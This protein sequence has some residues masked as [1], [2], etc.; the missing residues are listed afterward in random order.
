MGD[1]AQEFN[2]G[3]KQL[4]I[5]LINGNPKFNSYLTALAICRN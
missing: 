3:K 2:V 5:D 4:K 1:L